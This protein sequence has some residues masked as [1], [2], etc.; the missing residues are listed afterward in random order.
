MDKVAKGIPHFCNSKF[1]I[2]AKRSLKAPHLNNILVFEIKSST[3]RTG[4]C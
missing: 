2:I 3:R 4:G 1:L